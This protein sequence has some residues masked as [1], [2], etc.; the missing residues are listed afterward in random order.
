MRRRCWGAYE[1]RTVANN[2]TRPDSAGRNEGRFHALVCAGHGQLVL[3]GGSRIRILEGVRRWIYSP[4]P[5]APTCADSGLGS[6]PLLSGVF[7]APG[8]EPSAG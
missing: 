1:A 3:R 4:L 8:G 6:T 2:R 5:R 7:L